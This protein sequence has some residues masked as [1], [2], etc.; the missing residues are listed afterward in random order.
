[1]L[2]VTIAQVREW[3]PRRKPTVK[4]EWE[5]SGSYR[6]HLCRIAPAVATAQELIARG[7]EPRITIRY[8]GTDREVVGWKETA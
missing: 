8:K 7:I 3:M 1:M 2:R 4:L 6:W 5:E